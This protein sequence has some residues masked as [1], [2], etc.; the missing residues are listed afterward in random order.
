MDRIEMVQEYVD[1]ILQCIDN[2]IERKC[3]YKHLYGVS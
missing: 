1:R 2:E 3:G